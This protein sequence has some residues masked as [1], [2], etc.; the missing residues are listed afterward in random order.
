MGQNRRLM[1]TFVILTGFGWGLLTPSPAVS[2]QG[3]SKPAARESPWDSPRDT[4]HLGR[5]KRNA[6]SNEGARAGNLTFDL[7]ESSS[8]STVSKSKLMG[9]ENVSDHVSGG[10]QYSAWNARILGWPGL[11]WVLTIGLVGVILLR[12]KSSR[13]NRV[14]SANGSTRREVPSNK[15]TVDLLE[16]TLRRRSRNPRPERMSPPES[17]TSL[18]PPPPLPGYRIRTR[19]KEGT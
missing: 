12:L 8:G 10:P 16:A 11:F 18:P 3:T 5:R 6:A 15:Q 19:S 13:S 2:Q 9:V 4:N 7:L 14:S 1:A 17:T